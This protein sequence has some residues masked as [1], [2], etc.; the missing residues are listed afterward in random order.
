MLV[1]VKQKNR[2]NSQAE[3]KRMLENQQKMIRAEIQKERISEAQK[4]KLMRDMLQMGVQEKEELRKAQKNARKRENEEFR[5]YL[6][7]LKTMENAEK[8]MNHRQKNELIQNVQNYYQDYLNFK[9]RREEEE[10]LSDK[11]FL[12]QEKEKLEHEHKI[13]EEF[14]QKIKAGYKQDHRVL[15]QYNQLYKVL[16]FF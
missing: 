8:E 2:F 12:M 13:R 14:F 11:K 10:K 15:N 7:H 5:R 9:A 4:R 6:N 1:A 16:Y 3:D